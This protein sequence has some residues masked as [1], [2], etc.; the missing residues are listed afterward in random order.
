MPKSLKGRVLE[1]SIGQAKPSLRPADMIALVFERSPGWVYGAGNSRGFYGFIGGR[2]QAC[3][4]QFKG[5][6][7]VC[8]GVCQGELWLWLKY[9]YSI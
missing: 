3:Q 4:A 1:S 2:C 7:G 5:F 9:P 8:F 6:L